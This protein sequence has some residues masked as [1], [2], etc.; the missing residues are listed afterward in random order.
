VD[1]SHYL[2]AIRRAVPADFIAYVYILIINRAWP[3]VNIYTPNL[4]K[5]L[6][7]ISRTSEEG[8]GKFFE[9]VK[10]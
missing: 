7:T 5:N 1:R 9:P 2:I 4:E 3:D 6:E 10:S 8:T